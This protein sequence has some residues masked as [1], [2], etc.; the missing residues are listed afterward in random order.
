MTSS[1]NNAIINTENESEVINMRNLIY[2][3]S[4]NGFTYRTSNLADAREV[5]AKMGVPYSVSLK[6]PTQSKQYNAKRVEAIRAKAR[7]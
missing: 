6:T 7:A 2:T 4:S 3:V 5:S 1:K